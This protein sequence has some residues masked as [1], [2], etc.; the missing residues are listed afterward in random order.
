MGVLK[1]L[2]GFFKGGEG[3]VLLKSKGVL[4]ILRGSCREPRGILE[5]LG[6]A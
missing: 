6:G 3:V 5:S 1:A 2:K 4:K